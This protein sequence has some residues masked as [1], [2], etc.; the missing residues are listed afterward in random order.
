M[1]RTLRK[2][3]RN[4]ESWGKAVRNVIQSGVRMSSRDLRDRSGVR[5][6]PLVTKKATK[7]NI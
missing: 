2:R 6:S 3:E 7:I 4:L 1:K 5:H